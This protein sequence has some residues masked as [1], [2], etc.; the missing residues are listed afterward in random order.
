VEKYGYKTPVSANVCMDNWDDVDIQT[1]YYN[2]ENY[3]LNILRREDKAF[4]RAWYLFDENCPEHYSGET[5]VTFDAVYENQPVVET[6]RWDSD[7]DAAWYFDCKAE[8]F[9]TERLSDTALKISMGDMSVVMDELSVE[10]YGSGISFNAPQHRAKMT[11]E[12]NKISFEYSGRSYYLEVLE[13]R[14]E[15]CGDIAKIV[16][17]DGKIKF[18]FQV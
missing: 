18:G 8:S 5:C 12:E 16:P 6:I 17:K 15:R 7:F 1:A 9:V 2:C 14:V 3:V 10:V 13:G 4:I 11:L